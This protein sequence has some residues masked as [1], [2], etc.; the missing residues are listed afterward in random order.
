M[1]IRYKMIEHERI[2]D[3][4]FMGALICAISCNIGCKGC[5]NDPLKR[6]ETLISS[7]AMILDEIESNPFNEGIIL[8]G[9]EWS[10]Q[11]DELVSLVEEAVKR[12]LKVMIYTGYTAEIFFMKVPKLKGMSG[13]IFIKHGAYIEKLASE[14]HYMYGIKLATLNQRIDP[15]ESLIRGDLPLVI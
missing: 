15:L 7:Q 9:L 13:D 11:P 4:P 1:R 2:E 6:S 10:N 3:A 5:F 12:K 14:D 8:A